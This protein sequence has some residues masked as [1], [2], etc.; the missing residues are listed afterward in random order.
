MLLSNIT[1]PCWNCRG[2]KQDLKLLLVHFFHLLENEFNI[3]FE[4][5]FEHDI[6]FVQNDGLEIREV[7]ISSAHMILDPSGGSNENIDT[8]LKILGLAFDTD[9]TVDCHNLELVV[10]MLKLC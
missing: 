9:T 8:P 7:D 5:K 10:M 3:L 6:G 2:E 4:S 1:D